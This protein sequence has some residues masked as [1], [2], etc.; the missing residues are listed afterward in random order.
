[1]LKFLL[2]L[3]VLV[4][5]WKVFTATRRGPDRAKLAASRASIDSKSLFLSSFPECPQERLQAIYDGLIKALPVQGFPLL[6]DDRL[7][8][9]LGA[10]KKYVWDVIET[11][12]GK[13]GGNYDLARKK[14]PSEP[15][16]TP[17]DVVKW[18]DN[19]LNIKETE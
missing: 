17:R 1:M 18:I 14:L 10:G 9:T 19:A 4:I 3:I 15:V 8:D 16:Q 2:C 12:V 5:A 11:V 6:P 7:F 13:D